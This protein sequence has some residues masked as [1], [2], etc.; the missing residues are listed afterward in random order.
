MDEL[1]IEDKKYVSSKR[2]ASITGYAKDYIGQLCR[3]GRVPARLVGRSWYVLE[4]AIQ[5]HRFGAPATQEAKVEKD[6]PVLKP[7]WEAPRYEA[8]T[9]P[10]LTQEEEEVVIPQ[11]P[12]V[13]EEIE[14]FHDSWRNWFEH[15][16]EIE[17]APEESA[18]EPT[19]PALEEVK[20]E[21]K[22]EAE[23]EVVPIRSAYEMPPEIF[24]PKIK[25]HHF[26]Q[27]EVAV[28]IEEP[29]S[30]VEEEP[31]EVRQSPRLLHATVKLVGVM[32]AVGAAAV[33]ALGSG[34]LDNYVAS[35]NQ[36]SVITGISSYNK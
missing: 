24:L 12:E 11:D 32:V 22:I 14:P 9:L 13:K 27:K 29:V 4:S 35:F 36:A 3:E 5:D 18:P 16:A 23:G 2:A 31:T 17:Q 15:I 30:E 8:E 25:R 26:T 33:A 19:P 10:D 28:E 21:V 7:T 1:V 34:Y 20:E 6:V